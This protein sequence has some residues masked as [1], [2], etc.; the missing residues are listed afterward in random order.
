LFSI[1]TSRRNAPPEDQDTLIAACAIA[2]S[3]GLA[4]ARGARLLRSIWAALA[5]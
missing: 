5:G 2:G 1:P 3:A 4:R